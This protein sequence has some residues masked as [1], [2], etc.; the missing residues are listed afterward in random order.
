MPRRCKNFLK[1]YME[2]CEISESPSNFHFWTMISTVAAVL[3]RRVWID[4]IKFQWT[5]NF[6]MVLVAEAGVLAKSTTLQN[7]IQLVKKIKGLNF[8]P[9][10]VTW[11][12]L[13]QNLGDIREAFDIDGVYYDM[14][15]MTLKISELGTFLNSD[16]GQMLDV[17]TD[18]W[19]SPRGA[20]KKTT[21]TQGDDYIVSPWINLMSATTPSWIAQHINAHALEGGLIA[22]CIFVYGEQKARFVPYPSLVVSDAYDK[23]ESDLRNDLGHMA[24][25]VKGQYRLTPSATRWGVDWYERWEADK[26]DN[27]L[28]LSTRT[29]SFIARKPTHLHKL[30]MVIAATKKDAMVI[31]VEDLKDADLALIL[32]EESLPKVFSRVNMN[33]SS[34]AMTA[35]PSMLN[36]VHRLRKIDKMMLYRELFNT[37]RL[38]S[39]EYEVLLKSAIDA[40][41]ITLQKTGYKLYVHTTETEGTTL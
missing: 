23:L 14:S 34:A 28:M 6:Y 33:K 13:V 7:G 4:E 39:A 9:D 20:W 17:L 11:Q 15:A 5:P 41:E 35:V 36:I 22:R 37:Y 21:K 31:E 26:K 1:S 32:V 27:P 12:S 2:Y 16:D 3:R 25:A 40:G 29:A 8:G 38:T 18:L 24:E 10:A 19:D 30:A